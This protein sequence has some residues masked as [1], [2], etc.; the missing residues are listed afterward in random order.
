MTD[1]IID[2]STPETIELQVEAPSD[3]PV[4]D[5]PGAPRFLD[6]PLLTDMLVLTTP[7]AAP[8]P[9]LPTADID[10]SKVVA[11]KPR[12]PWLAALASWVPAVLFLNG[13]PQRRGRR[14]SHD[15]LPDR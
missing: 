10:L 11:E 3:P 15:H 4:A 2:I 5:A 8:L 7:V 13:E 9:N 12:F 6:T 14:T 1:P